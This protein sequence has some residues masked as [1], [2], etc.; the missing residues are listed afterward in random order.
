MGYDH[1]I[2]IPDLCRLLCSL[3]AGIGRMG[4]ATTTQ[5]NDLIRR[6]NEGDPTVRDELIARAYDRL[7]RLTWKM[8]K[9]FPRMGRR[10]EQEDVFH[11]SL[12]R[13][14]RALEAVPISSPG[15][16]FRLAAAQIRREL[17]DLIRHYYGPEGLAANYSSNLRDPC[18][19]TPPPGDSSG[20]S[21]FDPGRLAVWTEFHE[22]VEVLPDPERA[23]F[24]LLWYQGLTQAEAATLL[25]VSEATV[26]RR[27]VAA[28]ALLGEHCQVG[29]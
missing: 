17:L 20:T 6:M 1:P 7:K 10:I 8:F 18:D 12:V 29:G 5:L 13:L 3:P 16:F 28:R 22:K 23:V 11:Q 27:W 9:D 19:A 14:L 26:K 15:E 2:H 21:T 25:E 24:E 4:E